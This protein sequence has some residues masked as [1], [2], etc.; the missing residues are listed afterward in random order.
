MLGAPVPEA[1]IDQDRHS[2]TRK[3]D[4]HSSPTGAGHYWEIQPVAQASAVQLPPER[5]FRRRIASTLTLHSCPDGRCRREGLHAGSVYTRIPGIPI[6]WTEQAY[7]QASST[8]ARGT[9]RSHDVLTIEDPRE[10]MADAG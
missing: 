3:H 7:E 2:L 8:A 9:G 10:R 6:A 1:T 4:V 5:E